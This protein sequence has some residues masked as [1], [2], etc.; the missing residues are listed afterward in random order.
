MSKGIILYRWV[1]FFT[2]GGKSDGK[3]YK[4]SQSRWIP[5][6][7]WY[8]LSSTVGSREGDCYDLS[9]VPSIFHTGL[10]IKLQ[11]LRDIGNT[12]SK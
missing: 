7:D 5:Q 3:P 4:R 6:L 9:T 12:H 1:I 11:K 10:E 2:V 8:L